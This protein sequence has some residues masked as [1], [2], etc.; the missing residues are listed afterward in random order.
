MLMIG[1]TV[2]I[3]GMRWIHSFLR[4]GWKGVLTEVVSMWY[5]TMPCP[6][7]TTGITT[8]SSLCRK[9]CLTSRCCVL[10][11]SL[12][13]AVRILGIGSDDLWQNAWHVG[14]LSFFPPFLPWNA[15]ESMGIEFDILKGVVKEIR[16]F[17]SKWGRQRKFYSTLSGQSMILPS[18]WKFLLVLFCWSHTKPKLPIWSFYYLTFS[19]PKNLYILSANIDVLSLHDFIKL[20]WDI[21]L[22]TIVS[23]LPCKTP[24]IYCCDLLIHNLIR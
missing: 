23:S 4:N 20:N 3:G 21:P 12:N 11:F 15:N 6:Q 7:L 2:N 8:P 1:T 16:Y 22:G 13:S 5:I 14:A 19:W 18:S 9:S 24:S 17:M 10:I